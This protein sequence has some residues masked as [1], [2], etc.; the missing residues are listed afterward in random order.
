MDEFAKQILPINI[1]DEMRQS[2]LD[3]AMSVIVGRALPDVRDGLKPVHRRA[4]YAMSELGNDWN[5]AYKKSARVVGDCFVAGTLVHTETGL[6]P[7]QEIEPGSRVQMPDGS[8]SEVVEAFA[9]PPSAVIEVNLSNGYT[10]NVTPGQLFRVLQDDLTIAWEKA[11]HLAGKR[12][13]A[14]SPRALGGVE[15]HPDSSKN[16]L[17]YILGLLVAEGYLTDRGRSKRVGINMVDREPLA[18]FYEFCQEQEIAA[19]WGTVTPSPA[20]YQMQHRVRTSGLPEAY[21]ACSATSQYKQVPAWILADRRLFAPF[22]AGLMDGDGHL[23]AVDSKREAVIVST[24]KTLLVQVQAMLLDQGIHGSLTAEG[25]STRESRPHRLP[26]YQLW[27]TGEEAV[28]IA[29]WLFPHL[30]VSHKRDRA[31]QLIE[32]NGRV[33]NNAADCI[34]GRAIFATLSRSHVGG[35][36]YQDREGRQFRAGIKYP[37]GA[38]IRPFDCAQGKYAADLAD[39]DLSFRQL[40]EWGI[41][42]KL[43][44]IGSPLAER[45]RHLI[46]TYTVLQVETVQDRGQ[47]APTY[48][49]QIADDSHEF[50]VQGCAVHNCIGK[51]HPHGDTAVYDTIVRMA[52][53]FSLRYMLVD[54]QGNFG[55]VDGDAPAAMRYTEVR[56]MRI[57]HELL[58]DMDKETVDFAPNYDGSEQE[59]TVFPARF[60]NLLVNGSSGIAVGMA[61][62]IPPH[63]LREVIDACV[64]LIDDPLLSIDSLMRYLPGPDFP[65]AGIISGALGIR[66]AYH[67]GRGRI[68]VRARTAIE[69]DSESGKQAIIITELP[70]QVNKARL[71]EK[72]AE[73]VKEKKVEGI[74]E[75]R[76]ESDKDGMRVVIEL[77]RNEV[78]EVVLNNLYLHTTMQNVFGINMVSL[79]DG[80]PRTLTLKQMLEAFLRHRREVVTR[81]SLFE[82][83]KARARAHI[84]EGLAVA[85]ANIDPIIVL[86]KAAANPAEAKQGL[87]ST[88]W[89]PAVVSHLLEQADTEQARPSDLAPE[90]GLVDGFYH[91]SEAQAQAILDLR[92]HRLTGLEK[93]KIFDEYRGLLDQISALLRIL[94]DPDRLL[95]VIR[96]ELDLLRAQYGDERRTQILVDH[97][98]LSMED[99]ISEEDMVVTLSH[100]GYAK[101]Q[102]LSA[103]RAQRRGGRGKSATQMKDE[104]FIDK[105]FIANSHDTIL[106]FSDNGKVYWLKV[107]ELPQASRNARGKPMVNLLPL[108][109]GERISAVLP[110]REYT[111][112]SYVFMATAKG[113]VKKTAL[114]DFS[115]RRNSGIIAL[116]L[117]EGDH[118]I[119]VDITNGSQDVLL[120]STDGKAIRFPETT[121]RTM[122]RTARGVRGMQ[123]SEGAQVISLIIAY[124]GG[125]V[126]TATSHGFGKRTPVEDY[127]LKTHRGGQGVITIKTSDRNG[128]VVGAVQVNDDDDV[129]LI[130]NRSTLVRTPVAGISTMG[131]NTQGVSL[132]RMSD[133]ER[134]VGLERIMELQGENDDEEDDADLDP[135]EPAQADDADSAPTEE[136]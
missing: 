52:Q 5:K 105:L 71:V 62:N 97:Q 65:T 6:V 120:F 67:T 107:Y 81:R 104:D 94:R 38:K 44:R 116:D 100:A 33:L 79:V 103:Y 53:P 88:A 89:S 61:T 63:N 16:D 78:P 41:L 75:L 18:F 30:K 128:T 83:R 54:G 117:Q 127:P 82:L 68:Y 131:R 40:E 133:D 118:L 101:A 121:V 125:T 113:T 99:L 69:T 56:M 112:D 2:Y 93:D 47:I 42:H 46:D 25:A 134:L 136:S 43:A 37:N 51:Y 55:S 17:A 110:V 72:I 27:I 20:H 39:Q 26:C 4:L 66:E 32:G 73:L 7:I 60:P 28:R 36:W 1:E 106:C 57:A 126:L 22:L 135:N 115:R 15:N 96:E 11:E 21:D 14:A 90:F 85:L 58:A 76:D 3:Y 95:A 122:G 124:A 48:D 45:L 87:I 114:V 102:S 109:Q 108:E 74:T 91:L 35:G 80:Q 84:L 9:N 92:L 86:I 8:L 70:Y 64:A 31:Q 59:P 34:P 111:E 129:M 50:L 123:L 130:S 49:V 13:L 119:G 19:S 77:R 132:I 10:F 29:T 12:I 98:N 23:R 24:S